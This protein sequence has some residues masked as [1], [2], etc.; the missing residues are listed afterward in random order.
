MESL[1]TWSL[2]GVVL[3]R[4]HGCPSAEVNENINLG[5]SQD[6]RV[7]PSFRVRVWFRAILLCLI[8]KRVLVAH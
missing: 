3:L 7:T 4:W 1:S 6:D 2:A 8:L 5:Y